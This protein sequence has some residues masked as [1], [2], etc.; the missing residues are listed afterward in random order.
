MHLS[1]SHSNLDAR[2]HFSQTFGN[3]MQ[4]GHP[5]MDI[6]NAAAPAQFPFQGFLNHALVIFRHV[7]FHRQTIFRR[8]LNDTH[9]PA[10][11]QRHMQCTGNGCRRQGQYIDTLFP[12][13]DFFF[14]RYAKALFFIYDQ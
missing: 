9:I 2:N 11:D 10:V 8:R 6:I 5:V 14:L 12:L 7:S 4:A 3:Q 13:F 1:V